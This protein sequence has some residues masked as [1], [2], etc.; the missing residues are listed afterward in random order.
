MTIDE[1][2]RDENIH[3]AYLRE[4]CRRADESASQPGFTSRQQMRS[5]DAAIGRA[6]KLRRQ[7]NMS[8]HRL[9]ALERQ[10]HEQ[11][12]NDASVVDFTTLGPGDYV[13]DRHGWHEVVRVNAKSVTVTT[14]FSWNESIARDRVIETRAQRAAA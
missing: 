13:R 14:T 5:R 8:V 10:R 2:I 9:A 3:L 6:E 11:A 1:R 7:I 12:R 4:R